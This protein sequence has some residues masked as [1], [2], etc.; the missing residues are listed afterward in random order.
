MQLATLGLLVSS[1][2]SPPTAPCAT[3]YALVLA[4]AVAAARPALRC[5]AAATSPLAE[6]ASWLRCLSPVPAVMEVLGQGDVG[7]PGIGRPA[8]AVVALRPPG[9]R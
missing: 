6:A 1:R 8:S 2:A 7:A 5:C 9:R 4:L 3:T